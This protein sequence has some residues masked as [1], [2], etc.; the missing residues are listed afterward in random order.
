MKRI[1]A[2]F[3]LSISALFL[4]SAIGNIASLAYNSKEIDLY[5]PILSIETEPRSISIPLTVSNLVNER[6][7]VSF[8]VVCPP[9]WRY[10][11]LFKEYNVSRISLRERESIDLTFVLDPLETVEGQYNFSISALSDGRVI[12]NTLT[13][14]VKITRPTAVISIEVPS[15]EVSGSPGSVFSFRFNIKN[16]GYKD[17]T[18]RL[19]AE[20]PQGWYNLGFKPS[21]YETK[22]ISDVTV[23]ARSTYWS[24]TFDVYCPEG[25]EPGGYPV[26]IIVSEPAEGI[27]EK[28]SLRAI[29]TG[30]PKITLKTENDLLSYNVEAG[31]EIEIPL[32]IENTGTTH[33]REIS[34]YCYAPSGWSTAVTPSKVPGLPKGEKTSATLYIR[35][36]PGAIAGDYSVNVRAWSIDAT[37][38]ITLRITVTK[39]TYWGIIG[40]VVIIAAVF[41]LML[42]FWRYGRL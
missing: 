31:G 21:P 38:E 34:L 35:P 28:I 39:T 40:I 33:I 17:L 25:A 7:E 23:R 18:L 12:S 37:H 22:V 30:T 13:I 19:A 14:S 42:V 6:R 24:L 8:N 1:F 16:N 20:F 15:T 11:I 4:V 27:Y 5:S 36:S 26:N 2:L 29:V 9:G 41:G 32:I 3:I 10:N